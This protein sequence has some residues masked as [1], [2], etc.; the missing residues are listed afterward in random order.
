VPLFALARPH[1]AQKSLTRVDR[2]ANLAG[3]FAARRPVA[4]LRVLLL[5]DVVTTGATLDAAAAALRAGG[6]DV[7]GAA[8]LAVTPR[9]SA[10]WS[11]LL[12]R[13]TRDNGRGQD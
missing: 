9:Y 11:E 1:R 13:S 2:A 4:G 10:N 7:V 5:D 12:S 8:T 6:A 3:V